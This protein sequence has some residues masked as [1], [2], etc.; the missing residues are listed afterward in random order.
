MPFG[1]I[2]YYSMIMPE[3]IFFSK[4]QLTGRNDQLNSVKKGNNLILSA[5]RR[6]ISFML[7]FLLISV[8]TL[9]SQAVGDYRTNGNVQFNLPANWQVYDGTAWVAASV[10]PGLGSGVITIRNGRLHRQKL[11]IN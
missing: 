8:N 1:R 9:F 3:H 7:L 4:N 11:W 2:C 10:D 6:F 5:A